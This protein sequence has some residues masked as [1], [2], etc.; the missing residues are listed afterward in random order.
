MYSIAHSSRQHQCFLCLLKSIVCLAFLCKILLKK[1]LL[2]AISRRIL[3]LKDPTSKMSKSSPDVQSRILLTDTAAQIRS[4]IRGAVTDSITGIT[5]DPVARPG[6]SNLLTILAACTN[7]PIADVARRYEAKGHGHLKADV[8]EVVEEMIK[9]P[10]AE[11]ERIRHET[12]YL[13][14]VARDGAERAK[15]RSRIT[16][17]EVRAR[18]GLS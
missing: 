8:A 11:F 14:Q 2:L 13:N 16:M 10:R 4:K 5:Y 9:A 6:T 18:L 15:E 3:S 12:T 17:R 7:E 1:N